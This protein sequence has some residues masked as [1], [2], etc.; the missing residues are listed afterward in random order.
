MTLSIRPANPGDA[1]FASSL[2][3]LSMGELADYLFGG[4]HLSVEEILSGLFLLEKN[5]FSWKVMEIAEWN[6]K[7]VGILV[8]YPGW[9]FSDRELAIGVGLFKVSG[10]W[11]AMRLSVRALS[12]ASGVETLRNEYYLAHMAVSPDFQGRGIGTGLLAHA[13]I[14]A[15]QIG[16][17][18]CSLIVDTENLSA[19]RLY[20]RS[21][22]QV[23]FT[24]TY[25]GKV[26]QAHTGY[27]RMLKDLF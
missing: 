11:D 13:E 17:Y 20:Q 18:K 22:Y 25:S 5:R 26:A 21:G 27:H 2:I 6:G 23:V 19:L 16:L 8:S 15:Q 3:H 14:K 24:K 4:V 10:F 9:E 1:E 12:I 7:P